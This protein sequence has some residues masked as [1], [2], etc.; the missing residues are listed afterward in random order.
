MRRAPG[1]FADGAAVVVVGAGVVGAG[2]VIS[3]LLLVSADAGVVESVFVVV[4]AL[5]FAAGLTLAV[6]LLRLSVIYQPEP[7]KTIPTGWKT[8]RTWPSWPQIQI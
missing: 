8:R 6:S 7:L 5:A 2:V 3:L 4:S 1:Y